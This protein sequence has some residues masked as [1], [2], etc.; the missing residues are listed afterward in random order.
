MTNS[1]LELEAINHW[2][3]ELIKALDAVPWMKERRNELSRDLASNL[4]ESISHSFP[5]LQRTSENCNSLHKEVVLPATEFEAS[6]HMSSADYCFWSFETQ[7][8]NNPFPLLRPSVLNDFVC[9]DA[10]TRKMLKSTQSTNP[11]KDGFLGQF[12]HPIV[13]ALGRRTSKGINCLHKERIL[14]YV[15]RPSEG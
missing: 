6:I 5:F 8:A 1:R 15:H 3:S 13:P 4:L 7:P 2:R 14:F 12:I 11:N 9:I 10:K